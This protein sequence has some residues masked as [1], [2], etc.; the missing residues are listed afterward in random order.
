MDNKTQYQ[1]KPQLIEQLSFHEYIP[2]KN[3]VKSFDIHQ[4]LPWIVFFDAENNQKVC[5]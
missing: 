5:Y 2:L 4:N 1:I 3:K